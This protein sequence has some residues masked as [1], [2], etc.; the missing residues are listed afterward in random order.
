MGDLIVKL[1]PLKTPLDDDSLYSNLLRL[2][3]FQLQ[4]LYC[5][6]L[7]LELPRVLAPDLSSNCYSWLCI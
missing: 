2:R 1:D 5:R 6:L 3:A 4:Q 7:E